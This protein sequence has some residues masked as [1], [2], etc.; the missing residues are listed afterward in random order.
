MLVKKA[1]VREGD[2]QL[3]SSGLARL[4][5]GGY[6]CAHEPSKQQAMEKFKTREEFAKELNLSYATLKR[7]LKSLNIAI[8]RGLLSP[9][10]QQKI[11]QVLGFSSPGRPDDAQK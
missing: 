4:R 10:W 8:P 7:K 5:I 9:E 11:R 6:F 1:K 2:R 3:T